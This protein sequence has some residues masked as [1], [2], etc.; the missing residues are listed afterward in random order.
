MLNSFRKYQLFSPKIYTLKFLD[1]DFTFNFRGEGRTPRLST[2]DYIKTPKAS[3]SSNKRIFEKLKTDSNLWATDR[4]VIRKKKFIKNISTYD[5]NTNTSY[6]VEETNAG[7]VPT[8]TSSFVKKNNDLLSHSLSVNTEIRSIIQNFDKKINL[9]KKESK[10][11]KAEK[12]NFSSSNKNKS[13]NSN[14]LEFRRLEKNVSVSKSV[15][16]NDQLS[17]RRL[18]KTLSKTNSN[19]Y[20]LNSLKTHRINIKSFNE[21]INA[22]S[23]IAHEKP[24]L[25]EKEIDRYMGMLSNYIKNRQ[26]TKTVTT[27]K[28]LLNH[29]TRKVNNPWHNRASKQRVTNS[30]SM[31]NS[32]KSKIEYRQISNTE[33]KDSNKNTFGSVASSLRQQFSNKDRNSVVEKHKK[34]I[35]GAS[36]SITKTTRKRVPIEIE[37]HLNESQNTSNNAEN[38]EYIF[39]KSEFQR[40]ENSDMTESIFEKRPLNIDVR[41][42]SSSINDNTPDRRTSGYSEYLIKRNSTKESSNSHTPTHIN[43]ANVEITPDIKQ[44][45]TEIKNKE[46]VSLGVRRRPRKLRKQ[47]EVCNLI[48]FVFINSDSSLIISLKA[49]IS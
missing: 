34:V 13:G 48:I 36:S 5:Y 21:P 10:A 2:H 33:E 9:N 35:D 32:E 11:L 15:A 8:F 31:I 16:L 19:E 38:V 23:S 45:K 12:G 3:I 17:P 42:T 49:I 24:F 22:I 29:F 41:Y 25:K 30:S 27:L 46:K 1:L 6:K 20:G 4:P 43:V 26:D 28:I 18:N 47:M 39:E 37:L 7:K 44:R 40:V 14:R